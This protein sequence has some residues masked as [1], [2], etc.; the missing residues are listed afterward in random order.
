MNMSQDSHLSRWS[1]CI[2]LLLKECKYND[3]KT[4]VLPLYC[5]IKWNKPFS[6]DTVIHFS[7]SLPKAWTK[8]RLMTS[9]VIASPSLS[10]STTKMCFR[11]SML[12]CW[13]RGWFSNRV[14]RWIL[15]KPWLTNS[16]FIHDDCFYTALWTANIY[17]I[18][19]IC[20]SSYPR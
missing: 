6:I 10:T 15:K 3:S 4:Y 17:L 2:L 18:S 11:S 20:I 9:L 14:S 5:I 1:L 16:R 8:A 12:G 13:P 19:V 7:K